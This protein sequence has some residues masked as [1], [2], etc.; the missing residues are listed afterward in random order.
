MLFVSQGNIWGLNGKATGRLDLSFLFSL[1]SW[2]LWS[3]VWLPMIFVITPPLSE[4]CNFRTGIFVF[5]LFFVRWNQRYLGQWSHLLK[6]ASL[7]SLLYAILV[8]RLWPT[9]IEIHCE[10]CEKAL[11]EQVQIKCQEVG[12][13][14]RCWRRFPWRILSRNWG[15]LAHTQF[16]PHFINTLIIYLYIWLFDCKLDEASCDNVSK[17]RSLGEF[18]VRTLKPGARHIQESTDLVS[19]V[20][21]RVTFKGSFEGGF[22]EQVKGVHYS[23]PYFLGLTAPRNQPLHGAM[24]NP[25]DLLS[26]QDTALFQAVI[27]LSPGDYHRFHSP[28]NWQIHTRR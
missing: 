12:W 27:Y 17:Y 5:L 16:R 10:A 8:P 24:L 14:L 3:P 4:V 7:S 28:V 23:L 19:P 15:I 9:R 13:K 22:L 11:S 1:N 6:N 20:D 18:F 26:R 2:M 25:Q 21:G